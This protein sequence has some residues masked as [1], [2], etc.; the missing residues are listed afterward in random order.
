MLVRVKLNLPLLPR[1]KAGLSAMHAHADQFFTGPCSAPQSSRDWVPMSGY[2]A[3]AAGAA[4]AAASARAAARKEFAR[5]WQEHELALKLNQSQSQEPMTLSSIPWPD[6]NGEVYSLNYVVRRSAS[7][8]VLCY[9]RRNWSPPPPRAP[10]FG[11][12][13]PHT[14]HDVVPPAWGLFTVRNHRRRKARSSA[15]SPRQ[16]VAGIARG[17][18]A[19]NS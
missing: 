10:A 1:F 2:S 5:C 7:W 17:M 6:H 18:A 3:Q 12:S 15:S 4:A 14:T 19:V 11:L 9:P 13:Q 16:L 8:S